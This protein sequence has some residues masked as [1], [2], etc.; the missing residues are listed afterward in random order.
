LAW[1]EKARVHCIA[2]RR[3][4]VTRAQSAEL[5]R[6]IGALMNL[7]ADDPLAH[8]QIDGFTKGLDER[9]WKIGGNLQIDY[10][11]GAGDPNLYRKYAK[12]LVALTPDAI[13]GIGGTAVGA[14]Q[15]ATST[16]PIVFTKTTDPP[17]LGRELGA[18][19]W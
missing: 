5:I 7:L 6:R 17:W 11:W 18:T 12:E 19:R 3:P 13:L 2:W 4:I 8:I 14:L 9:G 16:I 10:R 15:E 1:N